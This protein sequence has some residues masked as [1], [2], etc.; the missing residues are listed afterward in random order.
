[1]CINKKNENISSR[2]ED[3]QQDYNFDID[4][5]MI[6]DL[7]KLKGIECVEKIRDHYE[8]VSGL[9]DRLHSNVLNGLTDDEK[10]LKNVL[11]NLVEMRYHRNRLKRL[12]KYIFKKKTFL[13]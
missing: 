2:N 8:G 7:M 12:L 13:C 6:G 5:E 1:V 3:I 10:I 4:N 11:K 9:A